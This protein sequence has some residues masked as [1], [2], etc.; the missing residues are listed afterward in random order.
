MAALVLSV[1]ALV[2]G[3]CLG[4]P[5]IED[6]WT[7]IDVRSS[8][9]SENQ[10]IT[11]GVRESIQVGTQITYRSI[12]TGYLVCDLRASSTI[13][14]SDVAIGLDAPRQRMA[15]DIDHL[16]QNSTCV[17]RGIRAVTGWDHLI[18]GINLSFAGVA[19]ATD[20][21]GAAIRGLFL[22]CYL[23]HGDKI[24]LANGMDSILI[25]PYRSTDYEYLSIGMN[26][27]VAPR[28]F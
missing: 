15:E 4:K 5:K 6:R 8:N 27:S 12:I 9:L 22:V 14:P 20:S 24:E 28:P 16:L 13:G 11:P 19:P 1:A 10:A 3:G 25:T 23:A 21:S 7:R 26:L 17:G 18:Q 2:L